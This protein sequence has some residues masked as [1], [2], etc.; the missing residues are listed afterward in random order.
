MPTSE[1][2][3]IQFR[4]SDGDKTTDAALK[5]TLFDKSDRLKRALKF[6]ALSWLAAGITLF[7]PLAHFVLVPSFFLLGIYL[8][9]SASKTHQAMDNASGSCPACKEAI[10]IKLEPKDSLPKWTYCP[11]C[12]NSLQ[13]TEQ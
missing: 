2:K 4:N 12:N 7:I 5:I 6:L 11:S 8:A 13:L 3:T 10:T 9:F 1:T